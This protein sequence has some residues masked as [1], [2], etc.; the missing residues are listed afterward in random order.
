[1]SVFDDDQPHSRRRRGF[2]EYDAEW[3]MR[4]SFTGHRGD[5]FRMYGSD[6]T[7]LHVAVDKGG[8]MD[9][10]LCNVSRQDGS[11]CRLPLAHDGPHIPF[12]PDL[13]AVGVYVTAIQG[14]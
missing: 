7:I 5:R 12:G 8:V 13:C 10:A 14:R 9:A 11:V 1:M 2:A 4:T 3:D 6:G